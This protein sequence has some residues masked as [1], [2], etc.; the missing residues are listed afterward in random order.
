LAW[1]GLSERDLANDRTLTLHVI[2]GEDAQVRVHKSQTIRI[3][4]IAMHDVPI[5]VLAKD[6]PAL[7][8]GRRF[9]DAM[10]GQDILGSR[11]VWF[12]FSTGRLFISGSENDT[13]IAR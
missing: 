2:A 1:L 3:G 13:A 5:V 11:R 7:A 9:R 12:S 4:P 10:I 6:L 8:G